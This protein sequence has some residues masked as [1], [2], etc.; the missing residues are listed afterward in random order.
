MPCGVEFW[1]QKHEWEGAE[2]DS[3]QLSVKQFKEEEMM[4]MFANSGRY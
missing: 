4:M 2:S 1:G 3:G